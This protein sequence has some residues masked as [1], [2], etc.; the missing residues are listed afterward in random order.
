MTRHIL[1]LN[2]L[3]FLV[4][5]SVLT[6]AEPNPEGKKTVESTEGITDNKPAVPSTAEALI[7][8]KRSLDLVGLGPSATL[9]ENSI[10][11]ETFPNASSPEEINRS[12]GA[13]T[14]EE[15]HRK[16]M[17]KVQYVLFKKYLEWGRRVYGQ[18]G[19]SFDRSIIS[20]AENTDSLQTYD[21]SRSEMVT[22]LMTSYL[23]IQLHDKQGNNNTEFFSTTAGPALLE[24]IDHI[25][26]EAGLYPTLRETTPPPASTAHTAL[27]PASTDAP[28]ESYVRVYSDDPHVYAGDWGM[29]INPKTKDVDSVTRGGPAQKAG[30]KSG[31]TVVRIDGVDVTDANVDDIIKCKPGEHKIFVFSRAGKEEVFEL[32]SVASA[33]P[34]ASNLNNSPG[35]VRESQAGAGV[36]SPKRQMR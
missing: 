16:V 30:I 35:A 13:S 33:G 5:L 11:R 14:P 34:R 19:Y 20:L 1:A 17:Q 7:R 26:E 15:A 29:Q 23:F 27:P 28:R 6:A 25:I 4:E 36:R 12:V 22:W 18:A 24:A 8:L 9:D 3:I 2:I 10:M 31:D 32:V 21:A